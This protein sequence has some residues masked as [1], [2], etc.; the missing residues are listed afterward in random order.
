MFMPQRGRKKSP[1]KKS[2]SKLTR[3]PKLP[4]LSLLIIECDTPYLNKQWRELGRD[5][6]QFIGVLPGGTS[7]EIAEINSEEDLRSTFTAYSEKYS[8]IN[9]V[10]VIGHANRDE[11]PLSQ[12]NETFLDWGVFASWFSYF[13]PKSMILAAC[14]AGQLPSKEAFFGEIPSL[15]SLFA[16]PLKLGRPQAEII[17]LLVP[18]LLLTPT[19]D[20]TVIEL[21][22][23]FT[24]LKTGAVILHC[25]RRDSDWNRFIQDLSSLT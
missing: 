17:K 18:Y 22:Q 14:E 10:V 2:A 25:K 1:R 9:L 5:I 3:K 13:K 11:I 19:I 6:G 24:F 21:G 12:S 8:S 4:S 16:S 20:P 15:K 23:W 7:V